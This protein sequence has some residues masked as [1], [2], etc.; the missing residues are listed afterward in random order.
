VAITQVQTVERKPRTF[1]VTDTQKALQALG[2]PAFDAEG[3]LIGL[4][5]LRRAPNAMADARLRGP[6]RSSFEMISRVV[7]PVAVVKTV[8]EDALRAAARTAPQP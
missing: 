2:G 1:V 4:V 6:I 3:A 7:V 8:A 5:G